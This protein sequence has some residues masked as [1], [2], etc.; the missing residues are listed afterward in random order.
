ME[1]LIGLI[2]G[3][4][5]GVVS[6]ALLKRLSLGLAPNSIIGII[7]GGL[8]A[9]SAALLGPGGLSGRGVDVL[10]MTGQ[11][12]TGATGGAALVIVLGLIKTKLRK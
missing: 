10:T 12:A 7:G 11:I 1:L 8:S 4:L 2:S 5:G 3:A 6:G 9:H